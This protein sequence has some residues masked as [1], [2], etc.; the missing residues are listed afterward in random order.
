MTFLHRLAFSIGI[1]PIQFLVKS[2]DTTLSRY[3]EFWKRKDI[4]G[5]RSLNHLEG[6]DLIIE[7][8]LSEEGLDVFSSCPFAIL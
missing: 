3:F 8:R 1:L 2:A 5:K 4:A 6:I 7:Q